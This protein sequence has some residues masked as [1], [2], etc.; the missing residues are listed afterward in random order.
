MTTIPPSSRTSNLPR[1]LLLLFGVFCGST[2]VIMIKASTEHPLLIAAF[3]LLTAATILSPLFFRDLRNWQ[4][5]Y[6][7]RELGWTA[8]PGLFLAL[9]FMSWI[10]GARISLVANASLIANLTPVAMPFFLMLFY[11]EKITRMELIGTACTLVGLLILGGANLRLNPETVHGD[12]ICFASM[13]AFA[14]Y[15]ALGRKNGPRLTIWLYM[16]PLYATAGLISLITASFVI[17]PIKSYTLENIL[18]ILGLAIIPTVFGH[19]ILNYSMKFFRG[20]V[21]SVTNLNQ[22]LFAGILGYL[23]FGEVP[24]PVFYLAALVIIIGVLIVL[25]A[26]WLARNRQVQALVGGQAGNPASAAMGE[27]VEGRAATSP[28]SDTIEPCPRS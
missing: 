16:V 9:H 7:W 17:N 14:A 11:R 20:Q 19:T 18:F 2:A 6:G 25:N 1:I 10:T 24:R 8:V 26:G 13:L 5:K 4:G 3:R 27:P 15:L 21:V 22:P 28:G 23:V 12:L